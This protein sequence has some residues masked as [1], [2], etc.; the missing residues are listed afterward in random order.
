MYLYMYAK[1]LSLYATINLMPCTPSK[2]AHRHEEF[3]M[4]AQAFKI[5]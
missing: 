1:Y 4:S 3:E 5:R 2:H